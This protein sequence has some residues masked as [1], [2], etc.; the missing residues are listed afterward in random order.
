MT[1]ISDIKHIFD[2]IKS[3][4]AYPTDHKKV[5][6]Q[7]KKVLNSQGLA[8]SI[9]Y[10]KL[11]YLDLN[12]FVVNAYYDPENDCTGLPSIDII[13]YHN[14]SRGRVWSDT[15]AAALLVEIFDALLHELEHQHQHRKK[16]PWHTV[17]QED[18]SEMDYLGDP[19]E[20]DAYSLSIT[21]ELLRHLSKDQIL[22]CLHDLSRLS[23]TR[24]RGLLISPNLYAYY[25]HYHDTAVINRLSKKIYK[26]LDTID[27]QDIFN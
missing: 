7:A 27:S 26:R 6:A 3:S 19:D 23:E 14:F 22:D 25:K 10:K 16:N 20:I 12:S 24:K 13:T 21:I 8:L 15:D 4:I 2:D 9:H 1:K 5:I 18:H 11:D 17:T